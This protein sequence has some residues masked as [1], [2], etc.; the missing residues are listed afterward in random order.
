MLDVPL[1]ELARSRPQ[2]FRACLAPLDRQRHHVLRW[3]RNPNAP[4]AW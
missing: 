4:P 1:D 2:I 3:S